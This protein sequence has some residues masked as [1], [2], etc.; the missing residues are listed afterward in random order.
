MFRSWL[1]EQPAHIR[2]LASSEEPS[3]AIRLLDFYKGDI[4]ESKRTI[5][6]IAA[7]VR[8]NCR[9]SMLTRDIVSRLNDRDAS[10]VCRCVQLS[11]ERYFDKLFDYGER[12][13]WP[14]GHQ[15]VDAMRSMPAECRDRLQQ[16]RRR[17][18]L[19]MMVE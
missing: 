3:A 4:A 13:Q 2:E 10:A 8:A 1:S 15:I 18:L 17:S 19:D 9:T 6:D 16:N 7:N 12:S 5:A 14:R 11:T